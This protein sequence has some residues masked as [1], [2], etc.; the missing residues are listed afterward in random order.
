M[1]AFRA[2][3]QHLQKKMF[4]EKRHLGIRLE[5]NRVMT[6]DEGSSES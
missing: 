2:E 4:C 6:G 1:S 3:E 5:R